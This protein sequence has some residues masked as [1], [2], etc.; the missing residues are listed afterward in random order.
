MGAWPAREAIGTFAL[1]GVTA[2]LGAQPVEF[3][4]TERKRDPR[5]G[6]ERTGFVPRGK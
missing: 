4:P 1:A 5:K 6:S 2:G 3:T